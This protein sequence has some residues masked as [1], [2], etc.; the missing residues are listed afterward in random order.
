MSPD[1]LRHPRFIIRVHFIHFGWNDPILTNGHIG[2]GHLSE[3]VNV[4]FVWREGAYSYGQRNLMGQLKSFAGFLH[5]AIAE[6]Y[7]LS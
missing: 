5:C 4:R 2:T 7:F 6:I 1:F 3:F